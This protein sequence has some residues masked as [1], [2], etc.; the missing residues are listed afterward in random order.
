MALAGGPAIT[1]QCGF[2]PA[3]K[4]ALDAKPFH[5]SGVGPMLSA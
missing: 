5:A 4:A 3:I 1:P 2:E